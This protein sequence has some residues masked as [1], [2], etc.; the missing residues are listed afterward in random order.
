M[1][2]VPQRQGRGGA[3]LPRRLLGLHWLG[4]PLCRAHNLRSI[5]TPQAVLNG[6]D[7]KRWG[8][9]PASQEAARANIT[10]QQLGADQFEA[11]VTPLAGL[12]TSGNWSAYWTITEHGHNSKVQSCENAGEFLQ[13]DFVVRQYA[14][15]RL[16]NQRHQ[17]AKTDPAQHYAHPRTRTPGQS[18]GV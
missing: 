16:Q 12:Q 13:H 1:G 4:R 7:W 11:R 2:F 15:R 6:K 9:Q 3:G 8:G 10:L 5:Y 18:G 17:P 14:G